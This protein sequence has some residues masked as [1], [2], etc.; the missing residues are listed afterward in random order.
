MQRKSTLSFAQK[1]SRERT[2]FYGCP[3]TGST[4]PARL[5][6]YLNDGE[7]SAVWLKSKRRM[8]DEKELWRGGS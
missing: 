8:L 2:S 6:T 4:L 3:G 1:A 5:F 7:P